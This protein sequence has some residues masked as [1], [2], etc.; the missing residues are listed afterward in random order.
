MTI[1]VEILGVPMLTEALGEKR[2]ELDV[3][4]SRVGDL[5]D[6]LIKRGGDPVKRALFAEDGTFDHS[7][8]IAVNGEKFVSVDEEGLELRDG[9][10]VTFMMLIGG[11]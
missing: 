11:G 8:Q 3:R 6:A 2:L 10:T 9:D 1:R 7:I 4:G 5:L